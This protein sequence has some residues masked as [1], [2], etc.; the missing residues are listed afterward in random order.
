M[1]PTSGMPGDSA[2]REPFWLGS[3]RVREARLPVTRR[4][5]I[6]LRSSAFRWSN[7][8]RAVNSN[9]SPISRTVG[10]TPCR[11]PNARMNSSTSRCRAVISLTLFPSPWS[12]SLWSPSP[13]PEP[14]QDDSQHPLSSTRKKKSLAGR[15]PGLTGRA[16]GEAGLPGFGDPLEVD[17]VG[18]T[19]APDPAALPAVEE[20][21]ASLGHVGL[22]L[23]DGDG[24]EVARARDRIR[25]RFGRRDRQ[26]R[27]LRDRGRR[28]LGQRVRLV[29]LE[30]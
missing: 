24:R 18:L 3:T 14:Q 7:A 6:P 16:R 2:R 26:G 17:P 8:A 10:G 25:Q 15:L 28:G 29:D 20:L 13:W 22:A 27:R 23:G 4:S 19:D 11:S 21:A 9:F 12:P 30:V 1:R 5:S